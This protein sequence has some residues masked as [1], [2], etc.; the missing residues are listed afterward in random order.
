[1]IIYATQAV[2]F[3]QFVYPLAEVQNKNN[4]QK[5]QMDL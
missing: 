1:M 2:V 5:I 3:C 4:C